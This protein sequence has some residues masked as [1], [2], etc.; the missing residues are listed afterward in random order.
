MAIGNRM[1][2]K[3]FAAIMWQV[4]GYQWKPVTDMQTHMTLCVHI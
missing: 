1:H 4:G 3:T 2:G